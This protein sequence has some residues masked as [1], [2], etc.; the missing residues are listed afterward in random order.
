ML[1]YVNG[2][3]VPEEHA[4]VSVFDRGFLFG[5]GVY[6]LVRFFGGVGVALDLHQARLARS[7]ELTGIVGFD[8]RTLVD[9]CAALLEGNA[10]TDAG[11]YIQITAARALRAH[12]CR[13]LARSNSCRT[14]LTQCTAC[15][16]PRTGN[17]ARHCSSGHALASLRN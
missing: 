1:A 7:L 3:L 17:T 5:D 8:A 2:S 9:I 14:G 10:L 13:C 12:T 15:R 6:E 11:I 4:K 16:V